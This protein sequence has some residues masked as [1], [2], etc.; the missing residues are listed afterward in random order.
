M[1]FYICRN[2]NASPGL[3]D[4]HT[5]KSSEPI[6]KLG[7]QST[8]FQ[9]HDDMAVGPA[10]QAAETQSLDID[11]RPPAKLPHEVPTIHIDYILYVLAS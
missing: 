7:Q 9:Y 8:L 6:T 1:L 4:S 3:S 2:K 11:N 5:S 10:D